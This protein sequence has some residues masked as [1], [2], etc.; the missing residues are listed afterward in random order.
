MLQIEQERAK[1]RKN[2]VKRLENKPNIPYD[3]EFLQFGYRLKAVRKIYGITITRLA[4]VANTY[5][6][7][8]S[9][10]EAGKRVPNLQTVEILYSALSKLGVD[11]L[12]L[13]WL[14]TAYQTTLKHCDSRRVG[15]VYKV[16][17]KLG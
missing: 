10:Y 16:L 2:A 11:Q 9:E 17:T 6:S 12:R 1:A 15:A 7:R 13:E 3:G 8:I 4:E 5:K 14:E